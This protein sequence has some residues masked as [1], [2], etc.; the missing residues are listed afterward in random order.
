M[1]TPATLLN[2]AIDAEFAYHSATNGDDRMEAFSLK[3]RAMV[4]AEWL[5]AQPVKEMTHVGPFGEIPFKKGQKVRVKKG[6]VIQ[7][8]HPQKR[9]YK[10]GTSH[11]V[12]L[13]LV[14]AGYVHTHHGLPEMFDPMVEWAGTG[15]YW[16][17]THP[18]NVE[19]VDGNG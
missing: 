7:S 13:H 11:T 17:W 12:E 15:G 3:E 5:D 10:A 8:T 2:I 4:C 6:A 18:N 14:C 9:T 19:L 16:C 1:F